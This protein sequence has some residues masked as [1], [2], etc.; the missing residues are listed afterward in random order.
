MHRYI[1]PLSMHHLLAQKTY[2]WIVILLRSMQNHSLRR[3]GNQKQRI[4]KL[5]SYC[6]YAEDESP[7]H[8]NIIKLQNNQLVIEKQKFRPPSLT[9]PYNF[10]GNL[11]DVEYNVVSAFASKISGS[12]IWLMSR[13]AIY[14]PW[15]ANLIPQPG[16]RSSARIFSC[17]FERTPFYLSK[18]FNSKLRPASL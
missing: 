12:K 14:W 13:L 17:K 4:G 18:G 11:D 2:R 16:R 15:R 10:N 6:P 5:R 8:L 1:N 3:T 7:N 9:W